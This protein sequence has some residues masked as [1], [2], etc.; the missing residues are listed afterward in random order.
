M[1][2]RLSAGS[3]P[4]RPF[5]RS[6]PICWMDGGGP[7]AAMMLVNPSWM[8]VRELLCRLRLTL[9]RPAQDTLHRVIRFMASVFVDWALTLRHLNHCRPRFRPRGRIVDRE[10]VPERV[11]AG[12]RETFDQMC[13]CTGAFETRFALKIDA[14]DN[15]CITLPVSAR[16]P[17]PLTNAPMRTPVQGDDASAVDHFIKNHNI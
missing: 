10:F 7:W 6:N 5:P 14:V 8:S 2:L 17:T 16:V 11:L 3:L 15:Q 4:Y 9:P 1:P 13:V 12:A